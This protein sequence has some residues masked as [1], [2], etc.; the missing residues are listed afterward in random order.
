[1]VAHPALEAA[2]TRI[3]LDGMGSDDHPAPEIEAALEC[4]RR[5]GDPIMLTGPLTALEPVL[6]RSSGE[7]ANVLL[8][9]APEVLEMADHPAESARKKALNSMAVGM[10]LVK[11]GEADAFV[12]A[13]N[14]GGAMANALF[15]LGRAR[16]VKRPALTPL[17]PVRG[18]Q[19]AVLDI[20]ANTD[21]RP[22]YLAQFAVMGSIY[23]EVV[24]GKHSP[25][26]AL[27]SNGEESGK[28]N[29]LIKDAYLL[30][31]QAG[32]NFIG[33]IEPKE[34]YAGHA[35]VVVADGFVGNVFLKT[36][37]AVAGFLSDLLR[38]HIQASP[39]TSVGGLLARPAFRRV[40][41]IMDPAE[42]GAVPL[43]G[44]DGLVFI[45]HGRSDAR[46]LVN[47]VKGA[48]LAVE[49]GLLPALR[50]AIQA[51]L[52]TVAEASA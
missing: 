28:G 31:Q 42:Y 36:S 12:T 18:G 24:Q 39:L 49:R 43:L 46:A 26:V 41:R 50:Q 37:E 48:R 13:G 2:V 23:A 51:R 33:N 19:C 4:A 25:R 17:F 8:V 16:G 32:L 22:E 1:L 21:C 38:E 35:D 40:G 14:T 30:I 11:H 52:G 20:G 10:D 27:L 45:G 3:V 7:K 47:A 34:L 44:L 15:R 6:R 9:D 29:Q 5:W